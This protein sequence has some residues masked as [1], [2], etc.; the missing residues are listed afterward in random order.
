MTTEP[1]VETT[2]GPVRGTRTG[3]VLRFAGIPYAA[4]PTGP[5]RFAAPEPP[6]PWTDPRDATRFG[7]R[8]PQNPSPLENMLGRPADLPPVDEDCLNLNVWTPA[9]DDARRPTMVWIHGGAFTTGAGSNPTYDGTALAARGD[10]VVVTVNYR[11]GVLGFLHTAELGGPPDSGAA[12]IAD[13]IAALRWVRDNITAFGGDPDNVTIFGESAGGMS[14]GALLASPGARGLFRRAI[15]QSGAAHHTVDVDRAAAVAA[16]VAAELG[17]T[18][19]DELRAVPVERLLEVQGQLLLAA[20]GA[21]PTL[22]DTAPSMLFQPVHGTSVIPT[23]A[24]DAVRAG[25]AAGVDLLV[26]TTLEE[27]KLFDLMAPRELTRA[28]L[29][30]RLGRFF[31]DPAAAA[32]AYEADWPGADPTGLWSAVRTDLVFRIPA[33]RLAEAAHERGSTVHAYRFS[34]RSRAF[35]GRLGACHAIELPFVFGGVESPVGR[36]FLGDGPPPVDLQHAVM[37]AW[38]A[39][40]R[41]GDP[42]H[43]GLGDW[44]AWDPVRRA[45]MDL[46]EPPAVLQD[47]GAATRALWDGLL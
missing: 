22:A 46:A 15:P 30:E 12:G 3:P 7:P 42:A 34:F 16:K 2:H 41:T 36:A 9:A 6:E 39:F 8:A 43:P 1:I 47:P 14:V 33:V 4:P 11:L 37:D 21:A 32:A 20:A 26:G 29:L 44:P 24:I 28:D 23:R 35:G 27:M 18:T 25:S 10:V 31:D 38:V 19:I 40:A 17:V 45:T 13:Q 5:R